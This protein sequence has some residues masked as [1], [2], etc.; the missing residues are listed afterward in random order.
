V[1]RHRDTWHSATPFLIFE[2]P[3]TYLLKFLY[4]LPIKARLFY[5]M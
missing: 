5:V 3:E 4:L 2:I 1:Y